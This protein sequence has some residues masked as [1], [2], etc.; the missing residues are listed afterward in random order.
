MALIQLVMNETVST[1]TGVSPFEAQ[2]GYLDSERHKL[3]DAILT[4]ASVDSDW[5]RAWSKMLADIRAASADFQEREHEKRESKE[6]ELFIQRRY[7]PTDFVCILRDKWHKSDKL[8]AH[9]EGP[10]SV[11]QHPQ[12]SN[13]V[14]VKSLI[15]GQEQTVDC[16]ELRAFVGTPAEAERLARSDNRQHELL[17]ISGHKGDPSTRTHMYFSLV[18]TDGDIIWKKWCADVC[19]TEVFETYCSADPWLSLLLQPAKDAKRQEKADDRQV[20][21]QALC[22]T[23]FYQNLRAFGTKWYEQLQHLPDHLTTV[24]LVRGVYGGFADQYCRHIHFTLPAYGISDTAS[25]YF[26]KY[27]AWRKEP[28]LDELVLEADDLDRYQLR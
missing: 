15:S 24:Y 13:H 14:R 1:R 7:Q 21:P 3:P 23:E 4:K 11:V 25:S 20:I 9:G 12:G 10:Y 6:G 28:G 16:R 26:V 2:F 27:H 19:N 18:F 5:V 17:R 8:S 22:G